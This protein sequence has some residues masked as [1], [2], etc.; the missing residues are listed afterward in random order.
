M[1]GSDGQRDQGLDDVMA[2][3]RAFPG[4]MHSHGL[5]SLDYADIRQS[6]ARSR[7]N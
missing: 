3:V 1:A 2:A 7:R 6:L 5:V 4:M